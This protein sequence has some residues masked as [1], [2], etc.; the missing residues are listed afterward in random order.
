VC[1]LTFLIICDVHVTFGHNLWPRHY[2]RMYSKPLDIHVM[3]FWSFLTLHNPYWHFLMFL[4]YFWCLL[5]YIGLIYT[6][7][8]YLYIPQ[9]IEYLCNVFPTLSNLFQS[10]F[11]FTLIDVPMFWLFL[12]VDRF[13]WLWCYY[14]FRLQSLWTISHIWTLRHHFYPSNVTITHTSPTTPI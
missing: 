9:T 1:I 8:D 5:A 13:H 10:L 6:S 2:T 3:S 7:M 12:I 14:T 4:C 11:I